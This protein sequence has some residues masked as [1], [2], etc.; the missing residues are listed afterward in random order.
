LSWPELLEEM[1]PNKQQRDEIF[2]R[3]GINP[4]MGAG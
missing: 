1:V 2:T 3:L 4:N